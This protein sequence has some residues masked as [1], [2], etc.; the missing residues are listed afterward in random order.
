MYYKK[1]VATTV[2]AKIYI[3]YINTGHVY[4]TYL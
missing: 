3:K 2:S 1:Q 4:N